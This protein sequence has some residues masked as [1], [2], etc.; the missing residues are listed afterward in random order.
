MI[1]D[2]WSLPSDM[3]QGEINTFIIIATKENNQLECSLIIIR[4]KIKGL[5]LDHYGNC[6]SIQCEKKLWNY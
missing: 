1:K 4:K 2:K 3:G 5:S 6:H